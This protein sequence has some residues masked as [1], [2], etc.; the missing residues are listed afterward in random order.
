MKVMLYNILP[1]W[2]MAVRN[3][4]HPQQSTRCSET[5]QR[6]RGMRDCATAVQKHAQ[7]GEEELGKIIIVIIM[8]ITITTKIMM[9]TMMM[10]MTMTMG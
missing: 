3:T 5:Q 8:I 4:T 10:M 6:S 7:E 2:C 9:M 1:Y